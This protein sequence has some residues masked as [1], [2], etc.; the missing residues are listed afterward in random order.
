[1]NF[2]AIGTRLRR[3]SRTGFAL[4]LT[5]ALAA[6]FGLAKRKAPPAP[7]IAMHTRASASP[8]EVDHP[9][10]AHDYGTLS[11]SFEANQGQTDPSVQFVSHGTGYTLFLT[12]SEAV[13]EL[14][15]EDS[16]TAALQK[17]K[18]KKRK[19]FEKR[20]FYRGSPRSRKLRK[21]QTVRV[22]MAGANPS[23]K[24]KPLE[25][26]PG[27]NSYFI[28]NDAKKWLTGIPTFER[29]K[30]SEIYPGI[31]LVYYGKQR[32]LEFDFV[33][34]PN[35]DPAKIGLKI[36]TNGHL[37][38]TNDGNLRVKT[39]G[40]SFEMR[41]PEIYQVEDGKRR[42]VAGRFVLRNDQSIGFQIGKYDH[43]Q[44][45]IIDPALAYSTYLGGNGTDD[46][47]GIAV[48][49][50]GNAY[51][52][53]QTTST[54]FPTLSGYTSSADASGIAFVSKLNP[55]GTAL[56]YSTY[57]GG[58]GGESGNGIALDPSGNVYLTGY[59]MSSDF[60]VVNGFQTSTGTTNANA[61][62][63]R[64]D[65]TQTG[66]ASLVYSTYLGGGGNSTN[67]IGDTG[68]AIAVDASGLAYVTGQ[69][70][71][72]TSV[73]AFPTT[74]G[75][76]QS[77]LAS[78][79][80]NGF[81]SVIDTNQAGAGSLIYSTY[82]GGSST[83]FGD[84]GLGVSV[85]ASGDAYV[86]GAA[87]S[88]S[89]TPFPTT[90]SAYQGS[91]NSPYGNAFVTEIATT[92]SGSASLVYSTY[93]G[94][95]GDSS[96][97]TG[98]TA[99][100]VALDSSGKLYV[101][102]AASSPDFPV[103][104][105][106]YQTTNPDNDR[107]F[108]AKLDLTQSGS[109]SLLYSTYLGGTGG[110]E[111][112]GI[113]VDANGN[114]YVVGITMSSDFPTTAGAFESALNSS[115]SDGFFTEL[116]SN[117]TSLIYST[118]LGGSCNNGDVGNGIALDSNGNPYLVGDTCS[119]DFP[120][121]PLG[122]YQTS[123]GGTQ[124]AFVTRFAL[125]A[126]PSISASVSPSPNVSG[127]NNS[128]VTVAFTCLPG[129]AP[130]SNCS[131]PATVSAEGA[132][133]L[134]SGTATDTSS[135]AATTTAT[136]NLDLTPPS[137]SI[138]SPP[139]GAA[140]GTPYVT[141]SGTLTDSLSGPGSVICN[142]VPAVL[143]GT[144][145]SC[146]LQLSSVSNSITV[147]GYDLA[148]NSSTTTLNVTVSMSAP[149][150]LIVSPAN[151][152][153]IT[154]GTQSFGVID[155]TGTRRPDAS[156]SVSDTTIA[157]LAADGSGT[158][159]GVAAGQVTLTATIG[160][161][162]ANTQVTVLAGSSLTPGTV[163]WSAPAVAGF[164][165]KQ[166]AQA[167]PTTNG[168]ALYSF[169]TDGAGDILIRSFTRDGG[170]MWQQ[171]PFSGTANGNDPQSSIIPDENGG[172]LLNALLYAPGENTAL[173]D[174]DGPTGTQVWQYTSPG[175]FVGNPAV[176]P[177]GSIV[178]VETDSAGDQSFLIALD[179]KTGQKVS[180]APIPSSFTFLHGGVVCDSTGTAPDP[181]ASTT[182][183]PIV[184]AQ[185]NAYVLYMLQGT[186]TLYMACEPSSAYTLTFSGSVSLLEV[187]PDGSS[188]TQLVQSYTA[189]D[190][191]A[192]NSGTYTE[193]CTGT[194]PAIQGLIPDG[195]Q[196][197]LTAWSGLSLCN[198]STAPPVNIADVSAHGMNAYTLPVPA[199]PYNVNFPMVLG[200]GGVAL[201]ADSPPY[202][203]SGAAPSVVSFNINSGQ[204]LW[205][206]TGSTN[207]QLGIFEATTGGVIVND[208]QLGL[209][210]LDSTG[211]PTSLFGGVTGLSYS[212]HGDVDAI[213]SLGSEERVY[214]TPTMLASTWAQAGGSPSAN[215]PG[216]PW[217]FKVNWQNTFNFI[218]YDPHERT[219]L[220]VDITSKATTIKSAALA[221]LKTAY[222]DWAVVVSVSEGLPGTGDNTAIVQ[223]VAPNPP[224]CGDTSSNQIGPKFTSYVSYQCSVEN[225]QW[226]LN[227]AINN[228]QDEAAAL[229]RQDLIEAIGRG[230]G[231]I[232]A[233]EI[234]HQ[235][236]SLC[237]NMDQNLSAGNAN[238]YNQANLSFADIFTGFANDG[239]P[240]KWDPVTSQSLGKCLSNGWT[241]YGFQTCATKIRLPSGSTQAGAWMQSQG[242][243][244]QML[245]DP[246]HLKKS[247]ATASNPRRNST[248][249]PDRRI[250]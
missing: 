19:L 14:Q 28:G 133:Q 23:P 150:S 196:G 154:G 233:H 231:N 122:A 75:A 25:E 34:A 152:N 26:L 85:D 131:S 239:Q 8:V 79:S 67:P 50:A 127:W 128:S 29:V 138:S 201:M 108:V 83:G 27:K 163:F 55:T 16:A 224:D 114:A 178:A 47:F 37:V 229:Q 99:L 97:E 94:G 101:S 171:S 195:Q 172:L 226:A 100:N 7:P 86:T 72:D 139:N 235:F 241:D 232:A 174:F 181:V 167:M 74:S 68:Y 190:A 64:I 228:A 54:N 222:K 237:C 202:S 98:D 80:G 209:V 69:T 197:V 110:D 182:L 176:R 198:S 146:T 52:V 111:G 10:L 53:G 242:R 24:I 179:G 189:T 30:Y 185:G 78:Q 116:N 142:N 105:G 170:Q 227:I 95:S 41:H 155:Q 70:T 71:S 240:I 140:V 33:V 106:A 183:G 57:L 66:T 113:A 173:A 22:A 60:P 159:T 218:P 248:R 158:L 245:A 15:Q 82:L 135:N 217:Y 11:L 129:G 234:A 84:Y 90:S 136:V 39:D 120:T 188:T 244:R 144:T 130:I 21:T 250:P 162:S 121:Y 92:Q 191:V 4:I 65:T 32:Q 246:P 148:G 207:G 102:G 107:A 18:S 51:V 31:D 187:A 61:F 230:A 124:N 186:Y 208:S 149:T 211:A 203:T 166:I 206:Y 177:D 219:D 58:T 220:Q 215:G 214:T 193:T 3:V 103:S 132:N 125:V 216:R 56:L 212:W 40:S 169:E 87:T 192:D 43:Q 225:A 134:I 89:P 123:L 223:D 48:D 17:M 147:I 199:S 119:S 2:K 49:A 59:T 6:S 96:D 145:F 175:I 62:V 238:V 243:P 213:S 76:Y 141:V 221:A 126:N 143:T 157:T 77:T 210:Q 165:T 117:G 93:L 168:P 249:I 73:A 112:F 156:W 12:K 137:L 1:M 180:S 46:G 5:C 91:L 151:P 20:K 104:S 236:L 184:D 204:V 35:A 115:F 118:Y 88:G 109:Q 13:I 81:L 36:E 44:Q 164:A 200:E 160:S 63:A 194:Y 42:L 153:I 247:D 9:R 38:L 161:V 45:L 205:T